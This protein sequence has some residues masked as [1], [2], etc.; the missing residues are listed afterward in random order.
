MWQRY[1]SQI[2]QDSFEAAKKS[3]PKLS[4]RGFAKRLD[5][6]PSVLS[7]IFR[8]QRK[9]SGKRAMEIALAAGLDEAVLRQLEKNIRSTTP[10]RPREL[11]SSEV[12][13]L[14]MNPLYYLL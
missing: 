6:S 8:D 13:D 3:D 9:I 14:V 12:V 11:L 5:V 1:F 10:A 7:E 2:L 4:L